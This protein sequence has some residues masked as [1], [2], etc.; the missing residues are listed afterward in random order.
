MFNVGWILSFCVTPNQDGQIDEGNRD[1]FPYLSWSPYDR[2]DI[3]KIDNF[4]NFFK[5]QFGINWNGVAQQMHLIPEYPYDFNWKVPDYNSENISAACGDCLIETKNNKFGLNCIITVRLSKKIQNTDE[6]RKQ[7]NANLDNIIK[8]QFSDN[9]VWAS[10]NSL[11]AEDI[12]FIVLSND[13]NIFSRFLD[14]LK[15]AT[16]IIEGKKEELFKALSSFVGFNIKE[17]SSNPKADLI[18]RLNLKDAN[19]YNNV[20]NILVTEE[21][22]HKNDIQRLLIGKCILDVKIKSSNRLLDK[23][24]SKG[25]FN[26]K[27]DFYKQYISSSRSYWVQSGYDMMPE[28]LNIVVLSNNVNH[29]K[30]LDSQHDNPNKKYDSYPL[31][32]FIINEYQRMI[33]SKSCSTWASILSKQYSVFIEFI[34]E[35]VNNNLIDEL[36]QL[37]KQVQNVL[38]HIRQASCSVAEIPYHNY[39]YSGSYNDILK[40]YY[41][42]ISTLFDIGYQMPHV[43]TIQHNIVFS[44]DFEPTNSIHSTMYSI[45]NKD[46]NNRFIIFHLP[47]RAFTDIEDTVKL[48]AHEVFHYIAPYSRLKRNR[49]LLGLWSK[50]VLAKIIEMI[51]QEDVLNHKKLKN[52]LTIIYADD[53][54]DEEIYKQT[55]N[56]NPDFHNLILNYFTNEECVNNILDIVNISFNVYFDKIAK[57]DGNVLKNLFKGNKDI[58][59][60]IIKDIRM[61]YLNDV[62]NN[63]F[64]DDIIRFA[65][66]SKEAFC[67]LNMIKIF[68]LSLEDYLNI[69]YKVLSEKF[70]NNLINRLKDIDWNISKIGIGSLERR[71]GMIIDNFIDYDNDTHIAL[72]K[73]KKIVTNNKRLSNNDEHFKYFIEYCINIYSDYLNKDTFYRNIFKELFKE[74]QAFWNTDNAYINKNVDDLRKVL[75]IGTSINKNISFISIFINKNVMSSNPKTDESFET[76]HIKSLGCTLKSEYHIHVSSLGEY[77]DEVCKITERMEGSAKNPIKTCWYRGVCSMNFNL[78]PSLHRM[79]KDNNNIKMSPYSYQAKVLKDAY[80]L[81][82]STPS[83]WTEQLHG[84]SEHTCCLQHYGMPTNLLDFSLD[85]IVALHFAITPDNTNDLKQVNTGNYIPKVVIFNPTKYSKAITSLKKG[86]VDNTDEY[87]QLSP[88]LFDLCDNQLN[89]EVF[90]DDMS[91]EYSLKLTEDFYKNHYIPSMRTNKYPKPIIIRQSNSRVLAQNGIFL[92]YSLQSYFDDNTKGFEY[93]DLKKIQQD[94]FSLIKNENAIQQEKFLEEIYIEPLCVDKLRKQLRKFG[95]T[96]SKMYP[97]L[98]KIFDDYKIHYL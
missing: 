12:V 3:R 73:F 7:I 94:Y 28:S 14:I 22:I 9:L 26:G 79:Y 61:T 27:S 83:L 93:M 10:F 42:I 6:V 47:F 69:F 5:S 77:L 37:L 1:N 85:M 67:D 80:F 55:Q 19:N 97:E 44:V 91:T 11:G 65:T 72:K 54:L 34:E 66:A 15:N 16:A 21:N 45:P 75:H 86:Y 25:V 36:Y 4:D 33:K 57:L 56:Q 88:V 87:N 18:I 62:K 24:H 31:L 39:T 84:I 96:A 35:Y 63:F 74:T 2:L 17:W 20:V 58:D 90:V 68:K 29:V 48:L 53:S 41:G 89:G 8:N 40:M 51:C 64:K 30:Y 13:I 71:L 76:I 52:I 98:S 43:K 59:E 95:M 38:L 50:S 78:L 46:N 49:L 60:D 23:F 92:A 32:Q 82:M 70:E 81:T